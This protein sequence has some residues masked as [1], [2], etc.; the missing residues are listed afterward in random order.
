MDMNGRKFRRDFMLDS[1]RIRR[2][3]DEE[4]RS[5]ILRDARSMQF[6]FKRWGF[7]LEITPLHIRKGW[8]KMTPDEIFYP[9]T[10][11]LFLDNECIA[12]DMFITDLRQI[13]IK[14]KRYRHHYGTKKLREDIKELI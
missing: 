12:D 5:K 9:E 6:D 4:A 3:M 1:T 2:K 7:R 11:D 14:A 13:Y 8:K 10:Y